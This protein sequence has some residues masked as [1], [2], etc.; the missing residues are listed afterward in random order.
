MIGDQ[1]A[2]ENETT[3][4]L[5]FALRSVCDNGFGWL[6][7]HG[8]ID[9]AQGLPLWITCRMTHVAAIGTLLGHPGCQQALEH[10]ITAL[11]GPF[12]D[13]QY[14]GWYTALDSNGQPTDDSKTAYPHAFVILAA[15][16]ATAA[17]CEAAQPLLLQALA[18]SDHHFWDEK[19]G[20][21]VEE[22]DRTFTHLDPYRGVNANMHTVEAYLAAAD[23][24]DLIGDPA[25]T[26]WRDRATAIADRAINREARGNGWHIPEHFDSNW[27]HL[28]DFNRDHPADQFRPY[29]ATIGHG[30]EWAR[31]CLQI[32]AA[33]DDHPAWM[34]EA[35][36]A[37]FNRSLADGWCVDG[38]DGFVYTIDWDG[39]PVVHERMHW[40]L[41]EAIGAAAALAKS[42][43]PAPAQWL[44][45]WWE[46]AD[47]YLI[48]H[49]LG[50]WHHELDRTNHPS[51]TVW[52]G[53]PDVY[54]AIQATLFE[55][56]PLSPALVPALRQ[57]QATQ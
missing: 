3:R 41:A 24:L 20:M 6:D 49:D 38:A 14:G 15:A 34:L 48:D 25:S 7:D 13:K 46:Y 40:V 44:P 28:L 26:L 30:M 42:G 36:Q 5:G 19:A 22:W 45:R 51:A 54:H 39:T 11:N 37:L 21:V 50:S 18:I 32:R 10:G 35:A 56:L 47:R 55:D 1:E 27:N 8:E 53:K 31:L 23:A 16:S 52:S 4:L 57:R 2:R 29:G 17:G 43:I 9:P 33:R 12:H